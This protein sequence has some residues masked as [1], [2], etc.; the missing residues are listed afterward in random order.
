MTNEQLLKKLTRKSKTLSNHSGR[1]Y[2]NC[3]Y[4]SMTLIDS[5]HELADEAKERGIW[6]GWCNS[7]GYSPDHDAIDYFA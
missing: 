4:S 2:T 5:Y 1:G 6:E 3:A 7:Q